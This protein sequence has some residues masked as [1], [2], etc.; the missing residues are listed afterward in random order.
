M[1]DDAGWQAALH[2]LAPM[3]QA[4]GGDLTAHVPPTYPGPDA[5][6]QLLQD[7]LPV[8]ERLDY[9]ARAANIEADNARADRN[10]DSL[11]AERQARV[12][13]YARHNRASEANT[14]RGQDVTDK[15]VRGSA[16]YQGR[17]GKGGAARPT[18]TGRN[19]QKVEWNGKAWVRVR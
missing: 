18:A 13:E 11:I 10:T 7:A 2:R 4:L 14:R 6:H 5:V 1:T 3:A 12:G 19:G 9:L 15:R 16:G 17:G 8:K